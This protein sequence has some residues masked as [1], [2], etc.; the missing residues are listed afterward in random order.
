MRQADPP[1]TTRA[2]SLR[3]RS[4]SLHLQ[5]FT[6]L[7][8]VLV[9][10]IVIGGMTLL[11]HWGPDLL[12]DL[13]LKHNAST[14][15]EGLAFDATGRPVKLKTS[16]KEAAAYDILREDC[17][18]R[19]LDAQGRVLLAS[20]GAMRPYT[21]PG[22]DFS[23]ERERLTL[24]AGERTLQ[25][26]TRRFEHAGKTFYVQ[27]MRSERLLQ[28][29]LDDKSQRLTSLVIIGTIVGTLLFSLVVAVSLHHLLK[30]LR[31]A[32]TAAA[33]ID[34]DNL[35]A[36]LSLQGVP[37]EIT[38]LF[39]S[40]NLALDRLE[41]GYRQ[42]RDFLSTAAH[43][44]KTPLALMR[45]QVE[46]G[47]AGDRATLLQDIDRM[48]RQVQ[49]LLTLAEA[50]EHHNYAMQE[51]LPRA[52]LAQ[53]GAQLDRL[54]RQRQVQLQLPDT[55]APHATPI[56][57]DIGALGVLCR[58][59]LENAL[60]HS[61]PGTVVV[62][63]ADHQKL[64]VRDQGPGIPAE[65]MPHLFERFW[66]GPH[67]RDEGA[68]LGLSICAEIARAHGWTLRATNG[69]EGALFEVDF[70][71]AGGAGGPAHQLP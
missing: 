69:Q 66:R 55:S 51:T 30:P 20:D 13:A 28:I 22:A 59:L 8:L 52:A 29:V 11:L 57:A 21:L 36:R 37:S 17:V 39:Q 1:A 32:A 49:Q 6:A 16:D 19:I 34:I 63:E 44:L 67:R 31:R 58:N 62:A 3:K 42:Q 14:V 23:A 40:V 70:N 53:A 48:A 43:E 9:S 24:V 7:I 54:A 64:S 45:G 33:T 47:E 27:V 56:H 60:H 25:V 15:I 38:P 12:T 61:P 41:Q 26:L 50:S 4:L 35:S 18:Y 5:A 46:L 10:A 68:G 71:P 65:A 2:R